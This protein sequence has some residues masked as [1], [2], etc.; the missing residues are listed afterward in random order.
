MQGIIGKEIG[1]VDSGKRSSVGTADPQMLCF[2][3]SKTALFGGEVDEP[4][5]LLPWWLII[6]LEEM[7]GRRGLRIIRYDKTYLYRA[8]A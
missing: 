5:Y 4:L 3:C 1:E 7:K 6:Y 8:M 2:N